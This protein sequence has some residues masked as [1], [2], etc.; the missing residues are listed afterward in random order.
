MTEALPPSSFLQ[1][2]LSHE[3]QL[4]PFLP[5]LF[6]PYQK[7]F[8]ILFNSSHNARGIRNVLI[9]YD[10][11]GCAIDSMRISF[12][13]LDRNQFLH[14]CNLFH[15]LSFKKANIAFFDFPISNGNPRYLPVSSNGMLNRCIHIMAKENSRLLIVY[16][17][18]RPHHLIII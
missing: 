12:P 8:I 1:H 18:P 17:L 16:S 7:E 15:G 6:E 4:I 2:N 10:G 5:S 3:C 9:Q 11:I 13:A 14:S